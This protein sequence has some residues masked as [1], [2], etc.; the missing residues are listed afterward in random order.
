M[1][2]IAARM[3]APPSPAGTGHQFESD[4]MSGRS[5]VQVL[6]DTF[7]R[8]S[9]VQMLL[10]RLSLLRSVVLPASHTQE[11][12]VCLVAISKS[13]VKQTLAQLATSLMSSKA[14]W[15]KQYKTISDK[16]VYGREKLV[17]L[18]LEFVYNPTC[19]KILLQ[20]YRSALPPRQR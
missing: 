20:N 15:C 5:F 14:L 13:L 18:V 2:S 3:Q 7:H 17:R 6:T 10:K 12:H 9:A 19:H 4:A 8:S 11:M 16:E 1:R